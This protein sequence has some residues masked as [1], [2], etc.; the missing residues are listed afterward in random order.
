MTTKPSCTTGN[1][2]AWTT[3]PLVVLDLEGS[4]AQ[5]RDSEAILE[6]A[7]VPLLG[8]RPGNV[9]SFPAAWWPRRAGEGPSYRPAGRAKM[10]SQRYSRRNSAGTA[11]TRGGPAARGKDLWPARGEQSERPVAGT[12]ETAQP[13][14][15]GIRATRSPGATRGV[16]RV[17]A[18]IGGQCQPTTPISALRVRSRPTA[19]QDLAAL[20]GQQLEEYKGDGFT[21]LR[22]QRGDLGQRRDGNGYVHVFGIVRLVTRA[23]SPGTAGWPGHHHSSGSRRRPVDTRWQRYCTCRRTPADR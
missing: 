17:P 1:T 23:P 12:D 21:D 10:F 6:I 13:G 7:I 4:G 15:A 19:R 18:Q 3:A 14:H 8:W 16:P 20:T 5:D 22:L 9:G 2:A 11:G